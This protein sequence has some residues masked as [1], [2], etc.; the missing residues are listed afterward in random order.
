MRALR[1]YMDDSQAQFAK[2]LGVSRFDVV[3][4]EK[5]GIAAAPDIEQRILALDNDEHL[6]LDLRRLNNR[7]IKR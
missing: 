7:P 4:W 1:A 2:R 5:Y 3:Y 6:N